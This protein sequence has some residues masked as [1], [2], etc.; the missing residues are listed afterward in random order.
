M[1]HL[2]VFVTGL[3]LSLCQSCFISVNLTVLLWCW[4][5]RQNQQLSKKEINTQKRDLI[6][7]N[8]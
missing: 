4:R 7:S 5:Q 3:E 1:F 6:H 2:L 8:V